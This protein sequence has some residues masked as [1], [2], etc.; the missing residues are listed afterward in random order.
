MSKKSDNKV[1][2]FYI[3]SNF[4]KLARRPGGIPRDDAL[5]YANSNVDA[6]K[7]DF[8]V[9]LDEQLNE[10]F[11][12]IPDQGSIEFKRLEWIDA[13]DIYIQHLADVA[14][15]MDYQFVSF[16]ASNLCMIFEAIKRG[17]EHN[18]EI[19][20]CHINA[21]RLARQQQYRGMRPEDLPELSEG[22]R[23][24]LNSPSLQ[25]LLDDGDK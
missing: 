24:V 5:R 23:R 2:E 1:R 7:P 18:S 15:P 6:F 9:W 20:I 12:L 25:P 16:V 13:V 3:E 21:L 8:P 10:F 4:E 22:L 19:I 11:A 14:A 17:A